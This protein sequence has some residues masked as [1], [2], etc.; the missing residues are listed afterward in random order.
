MPL[1]APTVHRATFG[2]SNP[3]NNTY[4]IVEGLPHGDI[5]FHS[6]GG[7]FRVKIANS[8]WSARRTIETDGGPTR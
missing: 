8:P 5:L 3:G 6:I 1:A 7:P 4:A 2:Q